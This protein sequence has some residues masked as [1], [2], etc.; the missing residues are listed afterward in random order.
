MT[1]S[2]WLDPR[3]RAVC[4]GV[5]CDLAPGHAGPHRGVKVVAQVH[6]WRDDLRGRNVER[7]AAPPQG[8]LRREWE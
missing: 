8:D 1:P 2:D 4:D 6:H 7:E 3:C 5:L